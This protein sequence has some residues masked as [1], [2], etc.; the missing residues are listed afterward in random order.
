MADQTVLE[1]N[2]TSCPGNQAC[3]DCL[4]RFILAERD[5][6]VVP[7]PR[8]GAASR[9]TMPAPYVPNLPAVPAMPAARPS[10]VA[11]LPADLAEVLAL[12]Q[13]A[14]MEPDVLAVEEHDAARAS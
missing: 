1:V 12:L 10:A 13:G 14:G 2:C 6:A 8:R 11:P 9:A 7:L 3:E 4:V 5:A